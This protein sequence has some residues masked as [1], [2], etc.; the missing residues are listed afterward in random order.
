M[1]TL[2]NIKLELLHSCLLITG[3]PESL[4]SE[5]AQIESYK[6]AFCIFKTTVKD[7]KDPQ[8]ETYLLALSILRNKLLN[9]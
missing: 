3:I 4:P 7:C 2:I 8:E 1:D 9:Q 6:E 5:L